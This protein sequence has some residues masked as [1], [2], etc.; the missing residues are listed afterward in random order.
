MSLGVFVLR[1]NDLFGGIQMDK[2]EIEKRDMLNAYHKAIKEG[3]NFN[4]DSWK[5]KRETRANRLF[6]KNV[7]IMSRAK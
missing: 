1:E 3:R 6:K 5:L 7:K 2:L 4:P